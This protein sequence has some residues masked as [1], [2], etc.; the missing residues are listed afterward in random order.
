MKAK[1]YFEEQII[2]ALQAVDRGSKADDVC[3]RLGVSNVTLLP[4]GGEVLGHAG[5]RREAAAAAR[6]REPEV[7]AHG[8]GPGPG[9]PG[10][11][12]GPPEKM[13]KR[14]AFRQAVGYLQTELEMSQ[15]R[16]CKV[17]GYCRPSVQY[18]SLRNPAEALV[19][20]EY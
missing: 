18:R 4:V 8:R 9:H 5:E 15:R 6:G 14:T 16:A 1:K 13:A 2:G 20:G 10:P 7:H 19:A 17:L 11:E 12:G 3:R